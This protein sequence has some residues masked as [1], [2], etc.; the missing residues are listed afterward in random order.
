MLKIFLYLEGRNR[1]RE[2]LWHQTV[3]SGLNVQE[4]KCLEPLVCGLNV[5]LKVRTGARFSF[6]Q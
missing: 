4:R 3:G 6:S 5:G 1:D 2:L